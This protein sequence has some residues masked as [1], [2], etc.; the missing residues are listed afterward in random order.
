[1][2]SLFK[3]LRLALIGLTFGAL[4]AVAASPVV[5]YWDTDTWATQLRHGPRP[6]AYLFTTSYCSTCPD[7]FSSLQKAAKHSALPVA[8]IPVFLDLD[9]GQASKHAAWFPGL[10]A[11]FVFDGFEPE[12]RQ[13]IDPHWQNVTPYIVLIDKSGQVQRMTGPA[14]VAALAKWLK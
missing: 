7:A 12:I 14:P 10:T 13:S 4:Q 11:L 8:L 3:V 5:Q 2:K 6:A 9:A 1:M